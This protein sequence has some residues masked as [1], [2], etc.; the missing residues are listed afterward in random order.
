VAMMNHW[1]AI[2]IGV[3]KRGVA[4]MIAHGGRSERAGIVFHLAH[5]SSARKGSRSITAN[6][7]R[8]KACLMTMVRT[9]DSRIEQ[10]TELTERVWLLK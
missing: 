6:G 3:D 5:P 8:L 2:V 4:Q 1:C 9:G 10:K 7:P